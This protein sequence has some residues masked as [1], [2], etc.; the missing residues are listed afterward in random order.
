MADHGRKQNET[1]LYHAEM[2]IIRRIE[3]KS[4]HGRQ[5]AIK[6]VQWYSGRVSDS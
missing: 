3:M 5:E 2:R 6:W 4:M 1:A